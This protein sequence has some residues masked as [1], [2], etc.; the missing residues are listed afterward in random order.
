MFPVLDNTSQVVRTTGTQYNVI[1]GNGL[2][3]LSAS[4]ISLAVSLNPENKPAASCLKFN[5][6]RYAHLLDL[7][8]FLV[9]EQDHCKNPGL[10]SR[11]SAKVILDAFERGFVERELALESRPKMI[12]GA[13]LDVIGP[14]RDYLTNLPGE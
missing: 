6:G 8:I 2:K 11:Q 1:T 10:G 12:M 3:G 9:E 14:H 5:R 4:F 7:Q 13:L